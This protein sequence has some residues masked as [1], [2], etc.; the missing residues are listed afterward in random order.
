MSPSLC[1]P[2]HKRHLTSSFAPIII[3][4]LEYVVLGIYVVLV[5]PEV[6]DT[7]ILLGRPVLPSHLNDRSHLRGKEME[8]KVKFEVRTS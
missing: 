2:C 6:S 5:F 4:P 1:R 8:Q 7:G 3:W